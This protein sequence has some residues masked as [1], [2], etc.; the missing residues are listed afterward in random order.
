MTGGGCTTVGANRPLTGQTSRGGG[1]GDGGGC[2]FTTAA[3]AAA[4]VHDC[5]CGFP[6]G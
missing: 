3:A 6:A 5:W 4:D 1:A 2:R